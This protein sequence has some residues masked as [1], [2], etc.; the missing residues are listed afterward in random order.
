[1]NRLASLLSRPKIILRTPQFKSLCSSSNIKSSSLA[2]ASHLL[3]LA[4][5]KQLKGDI[6]EAVNLT[7]RA[8]TKQREE[9]DPNEIADTA[10]FLG[11][12]LQ[13]QNKF[14]EAETSFN[15][16]YSIH[17]SLSP[18]KR[19]QYVA[20]S[21]LAHAQKKLRRYQDSEKNYCEALRG[22]EKTIGWK[23]GF[24]NHTSFELARLYREQRQDREASAAL[25][26][27]KGHLGDVFGKEDPRVLQINGEL[28]EIKFSLGDKKAAM[29]LLDELVNKLPPNSPEARRAFIRLEELK[30]QEGME[31]KV[32]DVSVTLTKGTQK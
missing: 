30:E 24:T 6:E 1:M 25:E 17:Q 13:L 8:L 2:S 15:E 23:D 26:S 7:N 21:H 10:L 14:N 31:V 11:K 22:L 16:S 4:T 9:N 18:N 29:F 20:Q 5:A 27:M 28:A 12:L 19:C 32:G 3:T